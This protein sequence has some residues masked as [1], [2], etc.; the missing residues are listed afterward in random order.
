[1][2]WIWNNLPNGRAT[3]WVDYDER[4]KFQSSWLLK[5]ERLPTD[6]GQAALISKQRSLAKLRQYAC[7]PVTVATPVI[8]GELARVLLTIVSDRDI[9]FYPVIVKAKDGDLLG[10][11]FVNPLRDVDCTDLDN[12]IVT[13]WL[14]PGEVAFAYDKLAHKP[15]C[16]KGSEIARDRVFSHVVVSDRL[17]DALVAT[18]ARELTFTKAEDMVGPHNKMKG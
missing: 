10:Y 8:N 11:R 6:S 3:V 5:R 9:Q 7:L 17:R 16:L 1:M 12:T 13:S 2:A 14:V 15:N 18:G 4:S